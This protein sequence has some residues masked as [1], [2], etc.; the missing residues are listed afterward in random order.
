MK[1]KRTYTKLKEHGEDMT[2]EN[3]STITNEDRGPGD[4]TLLI[5]MHKKEI[6]NW[7]QKES[8]WIKTDNLLA[9]TK[10][11]VEELSHKIVNQLRIIAELKHDNETYKK[12][13]EKLL[14]EKNK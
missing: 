13:I 2:H 12:E 7:K 6:W 8:E 1:D 14:A 5:E 10:K 9:G 4:L 3:E 11:V